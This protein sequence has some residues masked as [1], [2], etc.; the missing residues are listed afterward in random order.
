MLIPGV[1]AFLGFQLIAVFN[2]NFSQMLDGGEQM[3]HVVAMFLTL[4]S[5]LLLLTPAAYHRQ[6]ESGWVSQGFVNL[7]S[8]LIT[9]ATPAFAAG[10]TIDFYVLVRAVTHDTTLAVVFSLAVLLIAVVLWYGLPHV[11]PLERALR[12]RGR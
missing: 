4:V 5:L 1:T 9:A 10:I 12:G 11:R 8:R 3:L 6:A 2:Q 7:A